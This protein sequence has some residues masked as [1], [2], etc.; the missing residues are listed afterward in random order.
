VIL[1]TIKCKIC[2]ETFR[3]RVRDPEVL[4][5]NSIRENCCEHIIADDE[6]WDYLYWEYDDDYDDGS[7]F[8]GPRE[9]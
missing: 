3:V 1:A 7:D 6:A 4:D 9:E 5:D 8:L 2:N